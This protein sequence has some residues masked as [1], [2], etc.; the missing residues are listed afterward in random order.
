[1]KIVIK[2]NSMVEFDMDV[3]VD[4]II[5]RI[6]SYVASREW[7]RTRAAREAGFP[8]HTS[9]RGFDGSDW[10]PTASVLRK[11]EAII[12]NEFYLAAPDINVSQ[13][14]E[15]ALPKGERLPPTSTDQEPHH[16]SGERCHGGSPEEQ[17]SELDEIGRD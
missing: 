11:L 3:S 17:A 9:L 14:P 5:R 4:F 6:R 10:N 13:P 8:H 2:N 15:R 7:S 1:M 12:P 16:R